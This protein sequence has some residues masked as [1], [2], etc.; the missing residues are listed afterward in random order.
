MSPTWVE[1]TGLNLEAQNSKQDTSDLLASLGPTGLTVLSHTQSTPP[2]TQTWSHFSV[3]L[4]HLPDPLQT[5]TYQALLT[6]P[7]ELLDLLRQ[8]KLCTAHG[9]ANLLQ[10]Y[11]TEGGLRG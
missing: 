7:E 5:L 9:T 8:E 10:D 4:G 1:N 3:T 2:S 6:Q 11:G